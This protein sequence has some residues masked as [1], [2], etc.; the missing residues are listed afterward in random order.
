MAL[1]PDTDRSDPP[2]LRAARKQL[3][4]FGKWFALG[5]FLARILG[6]CADHAGRFCETAENFCASEGT[7]PD[8][9]NPTA[10]ASPDAGIDRDEPSTSHAQSPSTPTSSEATTP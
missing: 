6:I 8:R 7:A 10:S 4:A 1:L 2:A 9:P 5:R 3:G